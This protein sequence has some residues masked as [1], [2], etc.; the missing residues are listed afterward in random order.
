M[1]ALFHIYCNV[2]SS[3]SELRLSAIHFG[4]FVAICAFMGNESKTIGRGTLSYWINISLA[5]LAISTSLYLIFFENAL[6]ARETEYVTS[7]YVF[8]IIAITL[9]IEFT[10]R[11]TGWFMPALILTSLLIFFS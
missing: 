1:F 4:G 10:R 7:D 11:T 3:I 9:A 6:Y 5:L 8:S 2:F